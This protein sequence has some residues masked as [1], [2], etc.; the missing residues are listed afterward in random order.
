MIARVREVGDSRYAGR[1][2]IG[3]SIG[4]ATYPDR[5][6]T[7]EQLLEVADAAMYDA[8]K[9]GRSTYRFG[10]SPGHRTFNVVRTR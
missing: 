9:R 2:A 7:V 3:L 8:K 4:I 5:T 1:F 6:D 10:A